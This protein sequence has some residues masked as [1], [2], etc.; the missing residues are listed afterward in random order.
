M[1]R[2]RNGGVSFTG[3]DRGVML[4]I[5]RADQRPGADRRTAARDANEQLGAVHS[6]LKKQGATRLVSSD[7]AHPI[8][9]ALIMQMSPVVIRCT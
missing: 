5:W 7:K 9:L 6:P 1:G 4:R 3:Q 8:P 2:W